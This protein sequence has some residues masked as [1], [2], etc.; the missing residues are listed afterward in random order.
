MRHTSKD[1]DTA[2]EVRLLF[3]RD[4]SAAMRAMPMAM[5]AESVRAHYDALLLMK[6][7]RASA[8]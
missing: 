7:G 1:Y 8:T 6:D 5:S 2:P 3:T 4:K